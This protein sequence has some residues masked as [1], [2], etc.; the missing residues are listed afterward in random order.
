MKPRYKLA[1]DPI[2]YFLR[3]AAYFEL[4]VWRVFAASL[5]VYGCG[6]APSSV[7]STVPV[8]MGDAGAPVPDAMPMAIDAGTPTMADAPAPQP[9]QDAGAPVPEA[10]PLVDTSSCYIPGVANHICGS[11][12]TFFVLMQS[13]QS[14]PCA[15]LTPHCPAG[16]QCFGVGDPKNAQGVPI[17]NC[18][19]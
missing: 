11:G 12:D 6:G 9:E 5:L 3:R 18:V 19:Q 13:G 15:Q 14:V 4:C 1:A 16:H 2:R 7:G 17:G 10:A 8:V